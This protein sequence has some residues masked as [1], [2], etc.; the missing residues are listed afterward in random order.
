MKSI[1]SEQAQVGEA[2]SRIK[3]QQDK[4]LD[5]Y[6]PTNQKLKNLMLELV[7]LEKELEALDKEYE[8]LAKTL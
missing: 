4:V 7:Q 5:V 8:A 6:D 3:S 1:Y 2:I